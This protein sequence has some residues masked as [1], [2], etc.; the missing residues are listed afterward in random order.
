V[1]QG[2]YFVLDLDVANAADAEKMAK[3]ISDKVLANPVIESFTVEI[4]G[5]KK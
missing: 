2:K 5:A 1:R 4:D 3:D